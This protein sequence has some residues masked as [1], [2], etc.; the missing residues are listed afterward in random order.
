M[1][2]LARLDPGDAVTGLFFIVVLQTSVVILLAALLGRTVFRWRA[3]ARHVL[4]LGVL[5]LVLIS[6]AVA[7][8]ARR[9]GLALWAIALPVTG[10]G[11][12]P[13]HGDQRPSHEVA[14]SDSS[15]LAAELSTGS[16]AAETEPLHEAMAVTS[17]E[18]AQFEAARA[19]TP[20]LYRGGSS[21]M[22]GLTLLWVVGVLV[23]LARIAVGWTRM[24]ALC[25]VGMCTRSSAP[26]SDARARPGCAGRCR[27]TSRGHLAHGSCARRGR[28]VA[29]VGH[30]ARGTGRVARE[31]L[32]ARRLGPR[33][34]PCRPARRMGRTVAAPGRR[35]LLAAPAGSLRERPA[36]AGSRRGLR[37]PRAPVRRSP[38]LRSHPAGLD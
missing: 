25:P 10:R 19:T 23:G 20:E 12:S 2:L 22:G 4:W 26:R 18:P 38:R 15:R 6:P 13:A 17:V 28:P 35:A 27:A 30:L 33:M 31:R 36:H 14:R 21:L 3:E 7:V 9:S 5:V 1:N 34:C 32:A 8:V 29:S 37:Q 24:A 11:A 16:V